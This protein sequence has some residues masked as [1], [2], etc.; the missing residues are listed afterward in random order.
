VWR[1]EP[2]FYQRYTGAIS[3]DGRKIVG[4]WE[5]SSD[6]REWKRDFGLNYV[7]IAKG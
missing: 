1:D 7:R 6:G 3:E 2:R 5:G 4:T